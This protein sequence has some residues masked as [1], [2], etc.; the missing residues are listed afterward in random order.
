[1]WLSLKTQA[2]PPHVCASRNNFIEPYTTAFHSSQQSTLYSTRTI[3]LSV[4]SFLACSRRPNCGTDPISLQPSFVKINTSR[5]L[6]KWSSQSAVSP[7]AKSSPTSGNHTSR[8]WPKRSPT[9]KRW[10]ESGVGGIVVDGWSWHTWI[11]LRSFWSEF[12]HIFL[13]RNEGLWWRE[14]VY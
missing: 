1:M 5:V 10:I 13:D 11:W 12:D 4:L 2:C 6:A 7:A 14:Y 3:R 8:Y 9:V